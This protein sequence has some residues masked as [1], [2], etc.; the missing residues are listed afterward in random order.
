LA[1][2]NAGQPSEN[3]VLDVRELAGQSVDVAIGTIVDAFMPAGILDEVTARLA[4]E[5]ALATALAGVDTFDPS[6]LDINAIRIATLAFVT[7]LVFIQVAGDAGRSM[8]AIGP[9]AAAQREAEIRSVV[10]EVVDFV[11]TPLL[12]HAGPLIGEQHMSSLVSQLVRQALAEVA[13]W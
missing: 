13:T 8:S 4:I 5:E 1:R 6:A 7:E 10:R 9:V 2:A 3:G 12:S 11:G